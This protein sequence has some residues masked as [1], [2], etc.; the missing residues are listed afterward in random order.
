[1]ESKFLI[2][3]PEK[4]PTDICDEIAKRACYC[5]DR[6]LK[7][8]YQKAEN[9]LEVTTIK[10]GLAE[11]MTAKIY[12]LV[13]KMKSD[14]LIIQPKIIRG[15]T[16][17]SLEF[18]TTVFS[19]L[20]SQGDIATE[21]MGVITRS[22]EFLSLLQLFDNLFRRIGAEIFSAQVCDYNTLI[23]TDWLRR[24]GYFTS[25]AH[26]VTFAMHLREEFTQL[27]EF[28]T[29]HNDGQPLTF[30]SIDEITTPEYCLSPAVCYHAYGNL[31]NSKLTP[32]DNGL[33]VFTAMGRCFR[34]ESKNITDL[35]RLWEFSMREI[36]FV[37]EP[38]QVL[39]ARQKAID[40]IWNLIEILD[41]HA[42]LETA[43][44]PF[45]STEFS[46]LRYFQ[47]ANDLKYEL[48][49]PVS[50]EKSIAAASFNYHETFFGSKFNIST[51]GGEP[52]HTGCAAFGLERLVLAC[53][54]QMGLPA[55]I[56]R[57]QTAQE[58][59]LTS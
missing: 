22:G 25:F 35:D 27:E 28:A 29:R 15:R 17:D 13:E 3:L 24:A 49:L 55:T 53:L 32:E 56:E 4:L 10:D 57:L 26:S 54:A 43:S 2:S 33:K 8:N 58:S 14:R 18:D 45:F 7:S 31:K 42:A 50:Q 9:S 6:I 36:I 40:L 48:L 21:G 12:R 34:Y 37:G 52:V 59:L 39:E 30:N 38:A 47:L 11:E 20:T 5:D 46:A 41:L 23:P 19:Q 16:G 1:M 51:A 44:D